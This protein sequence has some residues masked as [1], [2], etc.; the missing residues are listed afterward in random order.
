MCYVLYIVSDDARSPL[1]GVKPHAVTRDRS[2]Q[3]N[4]VVSNQ[5]VRDIPRGAPILRRVDTKWSAVGVFS[6][7][8]DTSLVPVWLSKE[9]MSSELNFRPGEYVH[10]HIKCTSQSKPRPPL[11]SDIGRN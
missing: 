10:V 1:F 7:P 4:Y 5:V 9:N 8:T 6:S 11:P 2:G 3:F